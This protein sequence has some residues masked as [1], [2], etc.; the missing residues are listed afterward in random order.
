MTPEAGYLVENGTEREF[1][2]AL[3]IW[4]LLSSGIAIAAG[5][6]VR[7]RRRENMRLERRSRLLM[8]SVQGGIV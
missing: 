2:M 3:P 7:G 6:T 4:L 8:R 5:F 1:S